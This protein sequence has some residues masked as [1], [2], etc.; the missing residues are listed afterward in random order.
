MPQEKYH[1]IS[2]ETLLA[3]YSKDG[4]S[5]WLGALLQRYTL[6]LLGVCMKYLKDRTAAEDAVQQIFLQSLT[7]LKKY[8]ILNF[9]A[10]LYSISKNHCLA[11]LRSRKERLTDLEE[12]LLAE[13]NGL[14]ISLEKLE[15][16]EVYQAL[17]GC[18]ALLAEPQRM[19]VSLFYLEKKSYQQ[20]VLETGFNMMQVKSH[21][22]NG[23]RNLRNAL[24]KK[25]R[26]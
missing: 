8:P 13:D 11:L 3:N 5:E 22:Q 9:R 4:N 24:E 14:S 16:E 18:L 21:I 7:G 23:K 12:G 15:K 10:W 1:G 17:E 19:S 6:L 2:D 26:K 20:I 25:L